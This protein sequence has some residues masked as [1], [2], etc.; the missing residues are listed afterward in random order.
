MTCPFCGGQMQSGQ[1]TG[2]GRAPVRFIR[3]G[4]YP[5]KLDRLLADPNEGRLSA[6]KGNAFTG[7]KI[8]SHYCPACRKM[9]FET[10]IQ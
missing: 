4:A 2:D 6:A 1:I 7:F 9:I 8:D 5:T 10:D 3:E